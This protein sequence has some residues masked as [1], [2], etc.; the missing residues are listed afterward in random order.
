MPS[1]IR[2]SAP[3]P[4]LC[5]AVLSWGTAAGDLRSASAVTYE[6]WVLSALETELGPRFTAAVLEASRRGGQR[7]GLSGVWSPAGDDCR[8]EIL[9]L[10]PGDRSDGFQHWRRVAPGRTMAPVRLGRWQDVGGG[11]SVQ[12]ERAVG[13]EPLSLP[14]PGR[15]RMAFQPLESRG[16]AAEPLWRLAE[17]AAREWWTVIE[18]G[19]DRL[20]LRLADGAEQV[21]FRCRVVSFRLDG[22]AAQPLLP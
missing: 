10:A 11:V 4:S 2:V 12:I 21:L 22:R 17:V 13:P 14:E 16:G 20:R 8:E 18:A 6:P 9:V 19:A 3:V 15:S 5:A 7:G 1:A